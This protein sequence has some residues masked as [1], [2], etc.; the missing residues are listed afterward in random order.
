M[1]T[2]WQDL[3]YGAR[4]LSK[5]P[6]FTLIAA[7][8]LSLGIGANTAIFS[9]VNAVLLRPL[10]YPDPARLMQIGQSGTGGDDGSV[11]EPKFIFWR[12]QNQTFEAMA[13]YQ[14]IGS[15]VNLASG[16]DAEYV[17]ALKVSLDFFRALGVAPSLGRGFTREEDQPGGER[18]A[19]VS[20]G[21]WRRRFGADEGLIGRR[22]AINGANYTVVGVM[23]P[24]F[25]FL[26]DADVF[27][28]LRPSLEGDSDSN[29]GAI[30]RLKPGVT[31]AQAQADLKLV[32]EKYRAAFP[33]RMQPNESAAAVPLQRSQTAD[34][35]S[36]LW[37]LLGAVSFVLLIACA[38]VANLQLTRAAARQKEMAVRKALGASRARVARQ[39]ITEGV[40]LALVGGGAGLLLAVWGVDGL[41]RLIP[42]GALPYQ[43]EITL[44][45]R[46]LAFALA[47]SLATGF[48]FGLAPAF[49]MAR[50]DVNRALKEGTSRGTTAAAQGRLRGGLVVAEV[51]LSLTL[52]IGA[53]LMI[54]T[55]INLRRVAP[56]FD[57]RNVLT[58]QISPSGPNYDTTAKTSDFYRR[59]LERVKSLPGVEAAAVT[60]N[61][62]L[63]AQFR[64][65]FAVEGQPPHPESVQLRLITPEYFRALRI[66]LR[67]GR[68]F[69][70]ADTAGTGNV[71]VVN[72]A[73]ARQ[74]ISNAD[75]LN[76]QLQIGR[77]Q[78]SLKYAIVGVVGDTK[79]FGLGAAAPPMMYI[80]ASQSPDNLT[81]VMRRFLS[82]KFVVRTTADPLLAGEAVREQMRALDA[83][84]PVTA[85]RTMEQVASSSVAMERF[86]MT[87][88]G[89]FAALGLSLAA[90]GIYGVMSYTVAQRTPE[91]GVRMA[92]GA[93][94]SDIL[95]LL[96]VRQGL[97]LTLIGVGLGLLGALGLTRLMKSLLF[98]VSATDPLTFGSITSLLTVVALLACWIPARRATKVDPMI[99]LRCE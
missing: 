28:P 87:L 12:D 32:A 25:Q 65:P 79:H 31:E 62:P 5:Q 93:Q 14:T 50:V 61:L 1:Q 59:A 57:P 97:K 71:A 17:S 60:S 52:L 68:E 9:V 13:L 8:T 81:L 46:V 30:G 54:Q 63:S 82:V 53:A 44:D 49:Q 4:M 23:P 76:Q 41:T 56:G 99:A 94:A 40:L 96:V 75:P 20:D 88:L 66:P 22:V 48:V 42:E 24:G 72:A 58:F 92:I 55:F 11:G 19:I 6:G 33:R 64:M 67:Q 38:N 91:I 89:L 77:G 45:W 73:F 35:R 26:P 43:S 84:L 74:Y 36:L 86:N 27:T 78:R 98:G 39:L 7:L 85:L 15:G 10:P 29:Y 70:E 18:V 90:V 47:A 2:L 69:A 51:A 80:P 83:T 37:L 16:N 21:L 34:V 95:K 3:R